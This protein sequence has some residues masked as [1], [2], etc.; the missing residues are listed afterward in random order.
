MFPEGTRSRTGYLGEMHPGTSM[1]A[2]RTGV[3]VIPCAIMG[4][5]ALANPLHV[6]LHRSPFTIRIGEPIHFDARRKPAE[7]EVREATERIR[8]AIV[9]MLPAEYLPP[10][11]GT[12]TPPAAGS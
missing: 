8:A 2:L 5:E 4:T 1:V 10:Y 6:I 3:P 12:E 9:A 11:T 7:D